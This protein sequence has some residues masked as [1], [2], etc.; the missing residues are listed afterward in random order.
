MKVIH[1]KTL[2]SMHDSIRSC[3]FLLYRLQTKYCRNYHN[4]NY[5]NISLIAPSYFIY[6]CHFCVLF[7]KVRDVACFIQHSWWDCFMT[8]CTVLQGWMHKELNNVLTYAIYMFI[9]SLGHL[10]MSSSQSTTWMYWSHI[11]WEQRG[12]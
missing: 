4:W 12:R 2:L 9:V 8:R 10:A 3:M 11:T 1:L 7:V 5:I 6:M